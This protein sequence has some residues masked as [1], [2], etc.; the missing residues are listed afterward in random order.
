MF[1]CCACVAGSAEDVVVEA[2]HCN[3]QQHTLQTPETHPLRCVA[4]G[5]ESVVGRRCRGHTLQRSATHC[6]KLQHTCCVCVT[7]GGCRRRAH[8]LQHTATHCNAM[9]H[10]ATHLLR[11]RCGR[12]GGFRRRGVRCERQSQSRATSLLAPA[13]LLPRTY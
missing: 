6:N 7:G 11:L 10:A 5:A 12:R 4:G 8:T 1:T 9:H 2:T 13:P 3:A